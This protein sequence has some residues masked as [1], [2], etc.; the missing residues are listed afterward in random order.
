[1]S[2]DYRFDRL[3]IVEVENERFVVKYEENTIPGKVD[4]RLVEYE[5]RF[6]LGGVNESLGSTEILEKDIAGN[7]DK[8]LKHLQNNYSPAAE[9]EVLEELIDF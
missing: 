2:E 8:A 1:M 5:N 6:L 4:A 9:D 3:D 7:S